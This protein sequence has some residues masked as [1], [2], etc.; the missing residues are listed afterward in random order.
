MTDVRPAPG[1]GYLPGYRT[2]GYPPRSRTG[3]DCSRARPGTGR[4]ASHEPPYRDGLPVASPFRRAE[5]GSSRGTSTRGILPSVSPELFLGAVLFAVGAIFGSAVTALSWRL[6]RG[7]SWVHG[8][9]KCPSC[10]HVLG[11]LELVPLLSWLAAR[12]R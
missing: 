7:E 11:P 3:R 6:P 4:V 2:S 10:G 12:G 1:T 8:R 5:T 9:S